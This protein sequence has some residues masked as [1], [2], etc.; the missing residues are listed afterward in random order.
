[1][2]WLFWASIGTIAYTYLG[3]AGWLWLRCHWRRQVVRSTTHSPFLSI[4]MVVRNE[5]KVVGDKLRNLLEL[6]YP[7][8]GYEIVVVSDGSNDG[9]NEILSRYGESGKIRVILHAESEGK[10]A[11]LN[12]AIRASKGELIVFTDARQQIKPDAVRLLACDFADPMIGCSSGELMLG[13]AHKGEVSSR[14]GLYWTIEKKVREL[15]SNSGSV[16]GATGALYA[17]R[18]NLLVPIPRGTILDDVFIP[19]NIV[20]RGYRVVFNPKAH[21]WDSADQG[22]E[23]EFSRKVRTLTG[24]YQLLQLAPWLLSRSNPI[25]FEFVSHKLLRLLAPFAL[26]TALLTSMFLVGP[27]YRLAFFGQLGLYALCLIKMTPL[28]RGPVARVAEA[29]FTFVVLNSAAA[30]AFAHFV[31]GRKVAW[32]R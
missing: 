9:T 14:M 24:N 21:A 29:A 12:D 4:V 19:M 18:R 2:K 16:V 22:A 23:R 28:S 25:R 20:R 5:A 6:R 13:D 15:E 27:I 10:A 17:A 3:Y 32:G 7:S 31:T 8:D 30:V 26:L 1:M 11:G